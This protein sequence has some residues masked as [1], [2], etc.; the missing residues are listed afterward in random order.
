MIATPIGPV[1]L[2][3]GAPAGHEEHQHP[4]A[5]EKHARQ[6]EEQPP[7]HGVSDIIS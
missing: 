2:P 5:A 3:G 1:P 7:G 6:G 4:W